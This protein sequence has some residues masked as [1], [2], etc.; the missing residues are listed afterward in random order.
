MIIAMHLGGV[1]VRDGA[2]LCL[3]LAVL[4]LLALLPLDFLW[5]HVLGAIR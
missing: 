5:R 3:A 2:R 1:S 4:T